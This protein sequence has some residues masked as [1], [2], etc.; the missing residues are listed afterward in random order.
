MHGRP[1]AVQERGAGA[2]VDRL[3]PRRLH[4]ADRDQLIPE[5][6][7]RL[8]HRLEDEVAPRRI[9]MP[10]SGKHATREV[11]RTEAERRF[12]RS[13]ERRYHGVQERQCYCGAHGS[14]HE[15]AARKMLLRDD[16]GC[17]LFLLVDCATLLFDRAPVLFDRAPVLFDRATLTGSAGWLTFSAGSSL[18]RIWNGALSTMPMTMEESR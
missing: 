10:G 13:G 7:Q 16:H 11:D 17:S 15:S 1:Y 8:H 2:Q 6:F 5:P 18:V 12:R 4:L 14:A 9:G 3:A